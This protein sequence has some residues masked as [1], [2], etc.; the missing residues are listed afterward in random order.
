MKEKTK[1]LG[2]ALAMLGMSGIAFSNPAGENVV[3][4]SATVVRD[5]DSMSVMTGSNHTV[6][7]WDSFSIDSGQLSQF[8]Q[9][10]IDAAVLNRV[11]G[12]MPTEVLG[13][14]LSNG[15]I[16]VINPNGILIDSSGVVDTRGFIG[17]TLDISNESF[18]ANQDLVFSGNS[19]ASVVNKGAIIVREGDVFYWDVQSITRAKSMP[20]AEMFL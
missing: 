7:N 18:L 19:D 4:G 6:I 17:S 14:L 13:T 11:V 20:M 8:I 1:Y 3:V 16:A 15:R 5:G 2:T 12:T 10:G 9:P